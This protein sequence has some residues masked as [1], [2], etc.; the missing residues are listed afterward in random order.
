MF[1][2]RPL[3][4]F[5]D[6]KTG[7]VSLRWTDHTGNRYRADRQI[8]LQA[9][10]YKQLPSS[11]LML[12]PPP[13]IRALLSVG[14]EGWARAHMWKD[15]RVLTL[16]GTHADRIQFVGT[17][18]DTRGRSQTPAALSCLPL[19][20]PAPPSCSLSTLTLCPISHP[21]PVLHPREIERARAR[22]LKR[23]KAA[24][25]VWS[26]A[27]IFND[28]RPNEW[29]ADLRLAQ[30]SDRLSSPPARMKEYKRASRAEPS[31]M[32]GRGRGRASCKRQGPRPYHSMAHFAILPRAFLS[33]LFHNC[34]RNM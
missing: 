22:A 32:N 31:A 29:N 33:K 27:K 12:K 8:R 20:L 28:S 10:D 6:A 34:D 23:D 25:A 19:A 18:P 21:Q 2:S 7:W 30:S 17:R 1:L 9:T 14:W 26:N 16:P 5:S 4:F 3:I 11:A 15:G 24:A 13:T